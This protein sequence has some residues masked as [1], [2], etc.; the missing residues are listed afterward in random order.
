MHLVQIAFLL[1]LIP[2]IYF[3]IALGQLLWSC[4]WLAWFF[5]LCST[6]LI[7]FSVAYGHIAGSGSTP[8][9]SLVPGKTPAAT[10]YGQF[11]TLINGDEN[12]DFKFT[13]F[14]KKFT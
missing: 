14:R 1:N 9:N 5:W 10:V 7:Q 3:D 11:R 13:K 8:Y 4:L 6:V 2:T 12:T